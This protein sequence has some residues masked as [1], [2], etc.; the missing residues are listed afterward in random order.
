[1]N[2][3]SVINEEILRVR[4]LL[5]GDI[6]QS[7]HVT[8]IRSEYFV[9][10]YRTPGMAGAEAAG[11]AA[12]SQSTTVSLPELV[13][14]DDHFLVLRFI[15]SAARRHDFQSVLGR[16]L[17][18]MHKKTES[19]GFG[20]ETDNFIGRTRQKNSFKS[21]WSSF[22]TENRLGYQIELAGDKMLAEAW[23]RLRSRLPELLAGTEEPPCLIHGDL[24][25]G[26]VIS[27]SAG[28]PVLIDPAAYYGHREMELGM[29]MLFGGF[30][31]DFY[32]SYDEEYPL[33]PGWRG[34]MNLYILYH[35]LNHYNMFGGG[36]RSQALSLMRGYC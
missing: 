23:N 27:G 30:N 9:K 26:N 14:S 33:L 35:V 24:W 31:E 3:S 11:L 20:F 15:N 29:T 10:Y 13:D 2:F 8:T 34:R 12:M 18:A 5:G 16:Q 1:M 28:E 22:L 6:G 25:A 4:P 17:A 36:Y 21:D 32:A 7:F 19:E